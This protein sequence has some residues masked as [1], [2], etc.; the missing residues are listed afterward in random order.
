MSDFQKGPLSGIKVIEFGQ[1]AAGP[2]TGM[3]LGDLGADIVKVE[4]PDSGDGMREWPPFFVDEDGDGFSSNFASLNRNKRS[5]A[6]DF[7]NPDQLKRLQQLCQ[8]ADVIIE[9]YRPGVLSKFGLGYENL[10]LANPAL[11][12]CSISGYGQTGSY[13]QKGAFDVTVQAIS[14]LMSV[15]GDEDGNPVKCGVPVADFSAGLYSAYSITAA[16]LQTKQTGIGTH[17]D[18]SMLGSLL[19]I[20]ALQ[21]SEYFGN[22][23]V[24]RRL[25][26][27][28]PRNAPYQGFQGLDK[29]FVIAAGNDK[30]WREVALAVNQP[31]LANDP[32]FTTQAL[33]AANQKELAG[34]LQLSFSEKTAAAWLEEFDR[35]GVP[36]API[37]TFEDILNDPVVRELELLQDLELPG[38]QTT[39]TVPFPVKLSGF[40]NS[41]YRRPPKKGEHTEQ[42]F[43]EWQGN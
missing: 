29:P 37:N 7:K 39:S 30:L 26:T 16:L 42:V 15:T 8:H 10:K 31:E 41:I 1:I 22:G 2:F 5:I 3:L 17:I 23:K 6:V 38:G 9:N 33:R 14:G 24:P 11:I 12:Y 4:R 34:I 13:S 25:G 27:A 18:C 35:R 28:H 21:T 40:Q 32:R 36:C 43:D 20:S 19:G